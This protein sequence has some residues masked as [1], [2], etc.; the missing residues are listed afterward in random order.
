MKKTSVF[1]TAHSVKTQPLNGER[2]VKER[3]DI[4]AAIVVSV[5][6]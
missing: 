3:V 1:T 6:A 5:L 4:I 2:Q